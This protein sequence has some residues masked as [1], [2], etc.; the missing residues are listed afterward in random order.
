MSAFKGTTISSTIVKRLQ[1][2]EFQVEREGHVRTTQG[3]YIPDIVAKNGGSVTILDVV[4]L[5]TSLSHAHTV[6]QQKYSTP[7]L[8]AVIS[9]SRRPDVSSITSRLLGQ[10]ECLF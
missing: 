6:K 5:L 3:V 8:L 2:L 9:P 4:W 1:E 10:G 7:D